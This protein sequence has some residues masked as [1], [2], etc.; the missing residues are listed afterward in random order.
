MLHYI[1]S[2]L[3][4]RRLVHFRQYISRQAF[5]CGFWTNM[6]ISMEIPWEIKFGGKI[7]FKSWTSQAIG[8]VY[9]C[10]DIAIYCIAIIIIRILI[11]CTITLITLFFIDKSTLR[12][13]ISDYAITFFSSIFQKEISCLLKKTFFPTEFD[14]VKISGRYNYK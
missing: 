10:S 2:F 3:P 6:E 7:C 8:F 4:G 5:Q 13:I 1:C 12:C 9:S 11:N 14:I